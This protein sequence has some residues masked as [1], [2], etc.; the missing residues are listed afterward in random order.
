MRYT[1]TAKCTVGHLPPQR[2][3]RRH[4]LIMIARRRHITT[5]RRR[6][7]LIIT[8]HRRR[9]HQSCHCKPTCWLHLQQEEQRQQQSMQR[10]RGEINQAHTAAS[11]NCITFGAMG[12][13]MVGG[14]RQAGSFTPSSAPGCSPSSQRPQGWSGRLATTASAWA[15][16][17]SW[18]SCCC[19]HRSGS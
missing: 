6:R 3:R 18:P 11:C 5:A 4:Q 14:C 12:L 7:R 16:T 1:C 15:C 9:W 19:W 10:C 13:L 17:P 8:A 2:R